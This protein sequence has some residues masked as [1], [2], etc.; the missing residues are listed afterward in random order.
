MDMGLVDK[1]A[2]VC[3]ASKGLGR[4]SAAGMAA[5]G[6]NLVI[7]ARSEDE[8]TRTAEAI[9]KE[10]TVRVVPVVAD[11]SKEADCARL[12]E[13]AQ[14]E[15]GGFDILVNNAGGPPPG[16]FMDLTDEQWQ[17][18]FETNLLSTIRLIRLAI[19]VLKARGGGRI[20]NIVSISVKQPLDN[21]IISN[22]IR[23]GVVGLAKTLAQQLGPDQITVNNVLPGTILTDRVR[24]TSRSRAEQQGISVDKVL[25]QDAQT[26]P[27]RRIGKPE[28]LGALVTFLASAQAAWITGTSIQVD[29]GAFK[30]L[31]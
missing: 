26:V 10:H 5:E 27:L 13:T 6:A 19:P 8:L 28:D 15:F 16:F 11:V 25:E 12:I 30:G 14:R 21:L 17:T 4:A 23:A 22:S 9:A 3:A 29:G 2:V 18:G 31:M 7:C 1:I 24:V 20:V